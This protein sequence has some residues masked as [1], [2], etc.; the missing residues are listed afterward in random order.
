MWHQPI[1][2]ALGLHFFGSLAK[3][4]RLGLRE[5]IGHQQIVVPA[6]R[7][8][9]FVEPD[10]VARDE[11]RSLMDQLIKGMLAVGSRLAP[12]DRPSLVLDLLA[13]ER[14]VLAIA[15]RQGDRVPDWADLLGRAWN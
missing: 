14:H 1:G 13:V 4:E 11:L 12:I 3:C 8:E 9:S 6:Q 5:D 15:Q 10:K 7:I 2:R